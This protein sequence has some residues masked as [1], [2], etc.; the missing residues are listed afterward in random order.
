MGITWVL[1]GWLCQVC[2]YEMFGADRDDG[3]RECRPVLLKETFYGGLKQW[4]HMGA[5]DL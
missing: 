1:L 5:A 2:S 3:F 4:W